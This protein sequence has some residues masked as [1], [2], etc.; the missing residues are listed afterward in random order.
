MGLAANF[1][2]RL[3]QRYHW[4]AWAGQMMILYVSLKMISEGWFGDEGV[5]G[6]SK[7]FGV[8]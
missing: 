5:L 2:A 7:V 8:G 1:D 6:L 4:I 3:I